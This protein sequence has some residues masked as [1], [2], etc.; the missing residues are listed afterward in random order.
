MVWRENRNMSPSF[1]FQPHVFAT[2][3]AAPDAARRS[4]AN[5]SP[6]HQV[7]TRDA[8]GLFPGS[9]RW[10]VLHHAVFKRGLDHAFSSHDPAETTERPAVR[11]HRP[12]A[13]SHGDVRGKGRSRTTH[14]PC[15]VPRSFSILGPDGWALRPAGFLREHIG[16]VQDQRFGRPSLDNIRP[17]FGVIASPTP[18]CQ[19][20]LKYT[21]VDSGDSPRHVITKGRTIQG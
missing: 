21:R 18:G 11:Q 19:C 4:P 20:R 1:I 12:R 9:R 16:T 13:S 14:L 7:F 2:P 5:R 15:A 3:P 17:K 6:Q 8:A 10:E